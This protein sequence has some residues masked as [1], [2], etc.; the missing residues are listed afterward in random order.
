MRPGSQQRWFGR[1]V[2]ATAAAVFVA[3][4]GFASVGDSLAQNYQ[5]KDR[6]QKNAG[7]P[8]KGQVQQRR[9]AV[10]GG[11]MPNRGG[12]RG[13]ALGPH[14]MPNARIAPNAANQNLNPNLKG[15]NAR[16][17]RAPTR[18]QR[19]DRTSERKARTRVKTRT[20]R[21]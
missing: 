2:T 11:M 1:C 21:G 4:V 5:K 14:G 9:N 17:A 7:P 16:Q 18:S 19:A 12:F 20:P 8:V 13:Q 15:P 6:A 3:A 10:P